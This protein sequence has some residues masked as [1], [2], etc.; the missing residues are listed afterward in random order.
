[1]NEYVIVTDS[2]CD[3]TNEMANELELQ[4]IPL[5]L[6]LNGKEYRNYLDERDITYQDFYAALTK[7][8]TVSTSALNTADVSDALEPILKEGKDVIY[9]AFSSGLSNTYNA[10]RVAVEELRR[11]FPERKILVV[12][13]KCA[14]MGQGLLVYHAVQ[15]KRAGASIEQVQAYAEQ[16]IPS[17][18]HWFTVDDLYFLKNGGRISGTVCPAWEHVA[19]QARHACKRQGQA[20]KRFKG[21]RPR[22]RD[23]GAVRAYEEDRRQSERPGCVHQPRRLL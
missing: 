8:C 15:K 18:A 7:E 10:A 12:D 6:T 23:P 4:V 22:Q 17:L 2:S 20:G 11:Q 21:T 16:L 13:T 14:S 5:S 1:M 3:L 9:L 19:Y